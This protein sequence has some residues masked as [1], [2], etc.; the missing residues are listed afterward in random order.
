MSAKNIAVYTVIFGGYDRLLPGRVVGDGDYICFSDCDINPPTPWQARV[1]DMPCPDPRRAS[2]YF[3]DQSTVVLPEYEY[4][5]MH[6][7]NAVL[8]VL[9]EALLSYLSETDIAAFQHP[10][11]ESVYAEPYAVARTLKDK[12]VNME[13]QMRRYRSE[14]FSGYPFSACTL[15]VRRNTPA[16]QE[17]EKQWWYEV[18]NGSHR[19]QLSF[20]YVRWKLGV[21]ITYIPG[22]VFKTPMMRRGKH[23]GNKRHVR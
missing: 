23:K 10:Y 17:F 6:S 3:F 4:T 19:D 7:G 21:E 14:G 12:W 16:I 5:I 20:D 15:L 22:H 11:R 1:V 13:E 2:R 8:E 9:P 18:S